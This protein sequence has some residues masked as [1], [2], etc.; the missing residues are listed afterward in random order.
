M[1]ATEAPLLVDTFSGQENC[2]FSFSPL[3]FARA[4]AALIKTV[5]GQYYLLQRHYH[6]Y[7]RATA[8]LPQCYYV[9]IAS[10]LLP[11]IRTFLSASYPLAAGWD[12]YRD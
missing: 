11:A 2:T 6:Y 4:K 5:A 1:Y 12:D 9:N 7:H 10:Y 8:S 3:R